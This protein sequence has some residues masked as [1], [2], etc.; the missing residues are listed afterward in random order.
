MT[1]YKLE[2]EY[3]GTNYSGWQIQENAPSIQEAIQKAIFD[4]CG[5]KVLPYSAGRTDAGVHSIAITAHIDLAK[6]QAPYTILLATNSHLKNKNHNIS[7]LSVEKVSDDFHARF[8]C[9][10][11]H[12]IYKIANRFT[13]PIIDENRVWWLYNKDFNIELMNKTAQHLIGEHDFSTFRATQ[14]QAKSPIKVIDTIEVAKNKENEYIVEIRISAQSFLHHQVR[15]IVGSLV[16]VGSGKWSEEDF[17][18]AF[19]SCNRANGGPTAPACGL[20]FEKADY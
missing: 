9:K 12:Y 20:Y 15:N 11:R 10:Q 18:I 14:C 17:M 6:E 8:S 4:F 16:L 2:I 3:A 5:E 13:R 19:E 7:I 1:R